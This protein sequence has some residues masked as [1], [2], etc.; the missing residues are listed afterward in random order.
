M[1]PRNYRINVAPA[2]DLDIG[3]TGAPA[4]SPVILIPGLSDSWPSYL[5]LMAALPADLRAIALSLR[6]HGDSGKGAAGYAIADMA[7]DVLAVMDA[8]GLARAAV[9][10]HS[11]G[12][13]VA[14]GL[15]ALA[16]A[17]VSRL[18][19]IGAF[20]DMAANAAVTELWEQAILPMTDPV[21]PDFVRDFQAGAVGPET[22]PDVIDRAV[23]ESLKLAAEDWRSALGAARNADFGRAVAAFDRPVLILHGQRD[24]Y[25]LAAE[26]TRLARRTGRRL[27]SHPHWGHSPHWE[28]PEAVA[29]ELARFLAVEAAP[30]LT[31]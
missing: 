12:S 16:P 10:G 30:R 29:A 26:Q 19:L 14:Q 21:D 3:E 22:P 18:V 20:V 25:C 28:Q 9:V 4:G 6:G 31:A 27:I 17:R 23:A 13:V 15:A 24:A 7:R 5:P 11:L 8:L 2:L 1:N